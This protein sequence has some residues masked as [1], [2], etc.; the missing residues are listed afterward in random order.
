MI[1]YL[2]L[3]GMAG[4]FLWVDPLIDIGAQ[5]EEHVKAVGGPVETRLAS[6]PWQVPEAQGPIV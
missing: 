6:D 5:R 3:A 4:G 1:R 2:C